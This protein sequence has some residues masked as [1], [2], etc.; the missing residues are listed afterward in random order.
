MRN[1]KTFHTFLRRFLKFTRK[2]PDN[3]AF[4]F[5]V[6]WRV[7][8]EKVRV[9]VLHL[10]WTRRLQD[11]FKSARDRKF[12]INAFTANWFVTMM[13]LNWC[14]NWSI[15]ASDK[16]FRSLIFFF[17]FGDLF[18]AQKGSISTT[19]FIWSKPIVYCGLD[20]RVTSLWVA[21]QPQWTPLWELLKLNLHKLN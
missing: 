8:F 1:R 10:T 19:S 9:V 17:V 5:E 2:F 6:S 21:G 4:L 11:I 14:M 16:L 12:S 13:G 7:A 18:D 3:F 15:D 20:V